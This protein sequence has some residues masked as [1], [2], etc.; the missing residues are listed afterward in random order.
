M[1]GPLIARTASD[2]TTG[3]ASPVAPTIIAPARICA[4]R[5][6]SSI[7]SRTRARRASG[8]PVK[9]RSTKTVEM[10]LPSSPRSLSVRTEPGDQRDDLVRRLLE[11]LRQHQ[12]D[13]REEDVVDR[14]A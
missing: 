10:R 14:R 12:S 8:S 7:S 2:D 11:E 9:G 13:R 5:L 6:T 3:G 1:R 4:E